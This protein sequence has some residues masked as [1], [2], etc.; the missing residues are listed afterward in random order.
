MP[1][2]VTIS[3]L[4]G[5][6][7]FDVYIC[8]FNLTGCFYIDT[9]TNASIPYTFNV[10][11]PYD[12]AESYCVK[13]IDDLGC[14]ISGCSNVNPTPTPTNTVT[15]TNTPTIS[16]TP[17]ITPTISVTPSVTPTLG[18]TQT[19]TPTQSVTPTISL[20]P[21]S[22]QSPTPTPTITPTETVTITPT[23]SITQ[24]ITST[25]TLTPTPSPV[26]Y[27]YFVREVT[28]CTTGAIGGAVYTV[29]S[30]VPL[31]TNTYVILD[32]LSGVNCA[33]QIT[34]LTTGPSFD[35]TVSF[36]CGSSLPVL[37]CC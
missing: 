5:T 10:P 2:Q 24:T 11:A 3:T 20:S 23:P 6:S 8:Q 9:I 36:D 4:S 25:V 14:V 16:L 19:P 37:C 21:G 32:N 13:I 26:L 22:T 18:V 1:V 33:F 15:P 28:N 7:P 35:D 31:S 29:Q 12:T 34:G 17:S 27:Y 30:T